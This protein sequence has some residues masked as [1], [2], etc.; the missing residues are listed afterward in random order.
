MSAWVEI[1]IYPILGLRESHI[2]TRTSQI[3]LKHTNIDPF[4]SNRFEKQVK[5]SLNFHFEVSGV[6]LMA[7]AAIAGLRS[8]RSP[9]F[10]IIH[11]EYIF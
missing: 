11:T 7:A 5:S 6:I 10:Q 9:G 2:G 8:I 1:V 4:T 3:C